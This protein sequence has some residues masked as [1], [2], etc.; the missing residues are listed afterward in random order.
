MIELT[1]RV[2]M[3]YAEGMDD[4]EN[5]DNLNPYDQ[6]TQPGEFQSYEQGFLDGLFADGSNN[7]INN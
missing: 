6:V 2:E 3:A 5:G 1:D 7:H 4:A